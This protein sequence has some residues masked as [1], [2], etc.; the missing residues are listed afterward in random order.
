MHV[1]V[2]PN[3][4]S[5]NTLLGLYK[6]G[7]VKRSQEEPLTSAQLDAVATGDGPERAQRRTHVLECV[8]ASR[9]EQRKG[10][11]GT[12]LGAGDALFTGSS[13]SVPTINKAAW[14]PLPPRATR[15]GSTR[16]DKEGSEEEEEDL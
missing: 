8:S 13:E 1:R 4:C 10:I 11:R 7:G 15:K 2:R 6:K 5:L 16:Q 14:P 3:V 9:E 12:M